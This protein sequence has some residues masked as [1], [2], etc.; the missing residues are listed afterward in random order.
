MSVNLSTEK[1]L[2]AHALEGLT[3][4][5][6][7]KVKEKI[8]KKPGQTGGHFSV[9]YK[10]EKDG[11]F[12]FLKAY[13][14]GTFFNMEKN[15]TS[16]QNK[17]STK[18][19]ILKK[20]STAYEY[21]KNISELCEGEHVTK[22]SVVY[23]YGEVDLEGFVFDWVPYLIFRMADGDV[24]TNLEF[25]QKLNHAWRLKS[26]HDLA[27]G[28]KQLHS[29]EVTHQDLKP[30]NILL[31][32]QDSKICDLGRSTCLKFESPYDGMPFSGDWSYAPPE[33]W[34]GYYVSDRNKRSY[35][36]DTFMLG[37]MI[38][39]YFSGVTMSAL[40]QKNLPS[41]FNWLTWENGYK[42]VL[43]YID[44]S[45]YKSLEEFNENVKEHKWGSKL[46][47]LVEYL[48]NPYP[49]K[50]GYPKNIESSGSSYSMER[51]IST[52]DY[53]Q[54]KAEIEARIL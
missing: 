4:E 47:Q 6:G 36:I 37:S 27:V 48:C 26:L 51:F 45:F 11:E 10:V 49:E 5:G 38:T 35:A 42:E 14:F 41:K 22:V 7:W 21:E 34:Y 31:F 9:S 3:L 18:M 16:E 54:K 32:E 20:M 8:E 19:E 44:D 46:V 1:D 17:S 23:D 52:L 24:R 40:L 33:I 30:S 50:R 15:S 25:A 29:I 28:L 39:F 12:Y 13:D 2:A 53:L 43:T